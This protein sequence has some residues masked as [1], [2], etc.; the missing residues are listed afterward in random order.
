LR[1]TLARKLSREYIIWQGNCKYR[2]T[3]RQARKRTNNLREL[4][5]PYQVAD[6]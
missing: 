5:M 3:T 1:Q 4:P 6:F 2:R